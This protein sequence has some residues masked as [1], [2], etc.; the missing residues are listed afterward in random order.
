MNIKLVYSPAYNIGLLGLERFHPF[1]S[2]KYGRAMKML[3]Q[4]WGSRLRQTTI[5]PAR[6]IS[7]EGLLAV[8]TDAYLA[9]LRDP[10]YLANALEVSVV[11]RL[12]AWAIDWRILRPMRWATAGTILAAQEA[13]RTDGIV[14][15][16]SGG[17]HHAKP[18]RGEGFSIYAD[19]ALAVH[20]L[21][22]DG[23]LADTDR[24]AYVD[25]DVH[26][27]NGVCHCFMQ[28]PRVFI[29]D[30]FNQSIYPVFDVV[31]R[32]RV[33]C[34]VPLQRGCGDFEYLNALRSKLPA[35]LDSISRSG[36]VALAVYN[37]GTD[38]LR[39]D[40]LGL[41]NLSAGAVL[42]RDQFVLRELSRRGISTVMVPSGGYTRES[43]RLIAATLD[44]LIGGGLDGGTGGP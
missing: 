23:A 9:K 44:W 21:R 43:Y 33:D 25:C 11:K 1:D 42:E 35:F 36:R 37:A 14:A 13:M 24:V 38:V 28:D 32:R 10:T 2:R 40:P 17:Y 3:R 22:R 34:P 27:G 5:S 15:N 26:Q 4:H 30:M 7:R 39:G 41:L 19:V 29:F 12:P 31:A 18:D 8:H 20:R 16:L 6:P